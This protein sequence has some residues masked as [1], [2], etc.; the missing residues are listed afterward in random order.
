MRLDRT[1]RF[2]LAGLGLLTALTLATL[3]SLPPLAGT[4]TTNWLRAHGFEATIQDVD[5]D[6]FR[7]R[8]ALWGLQLRGH[9]P[10]LSAGERRLLDQLVQLYAQAGDRPP[11]VDEVTRQVGK[12]P[13]LVDKLLKLAAAQGTLVALSPTLYMHRDAERRLRRQVA[14]LLADGQG[15]TLSQIREALGT[16]RKYAVPLCEHF[17]SLG[18]TQRQ[19]DLRVLGPRAGELAEQTQGG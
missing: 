9:G 1:I 16:T 15:R 18:L 19:G 11:S 5:L 4:L 14:Q 2:I 10:K 13:E 17:D 12:R 8:L 7:G 3:V 6:P